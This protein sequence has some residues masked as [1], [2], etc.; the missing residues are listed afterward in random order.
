MATQ[1]GFPH[2]VFIVGDAEYGH[3]Q[4]LTTPVF[5]MELSMLPKRR[6]GQTRFLLA[7]L[8]TV[9]PSNRPPP[10]PRG[11]FLTPWDQRP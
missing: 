1:P 3:R 9:H 6:R 4:T 2:T 8:Q 10:Y 11:K 5:Y 7:A